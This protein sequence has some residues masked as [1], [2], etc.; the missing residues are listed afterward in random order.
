[1]PEAR[2]KRTI[3]L[4]CLMRAQNALYGLL[5]LSM[6]SD[7]RILPIAGGGSHH[8]QSILLLFTLA[9]IFVSYCC[10]NRL[11][12]LSGFNNTNLLSYSSVVHKS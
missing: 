2:L 10:C 12:K 3:T 4:T 8:S 7:L 9:T 11:P 1:M 6:L 5:Y